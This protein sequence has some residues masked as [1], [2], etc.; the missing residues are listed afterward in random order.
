MTCLKI[1]SICVLTV[2]C[3]AEQLVRAVDEPVYDPP[4]VEETPSEAEDYM[5]GTVPEVY[6]SDD[7][8]PRF[9]A[10]VWGWARAFTDDSGP[11]FDP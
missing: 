6:E 1:L 10:H 8:D 3:G 5:D 11:K 2:L 9:R 7:E 4:E